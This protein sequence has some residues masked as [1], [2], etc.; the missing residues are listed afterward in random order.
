MGTGTVVFAPGKDGGRDGAFEGTANCFPSETAPATGKFVIQAK[1]TSAPYATTRDSDFTTLWKKELPKIATLVAEGDCDIYLLF[2][3]RR[4]PADHKK[5]LKA[6]LKAKGVKQCEV[7]CLQTIDL[8]LGLNATLVD[9]LGLNK[10]KPP[11]RIQPDDLSEVIR[12][13]NLIHSAPDAEDSLHDLKYIALDKKNLI[14]SLSK[15]YYEYIQTASMPFFSQIRDF[16][17]NPRNSGLRD[18]YHTTADEIRG[19]L[20]TFQSQFARFEEVFVLLYD[21]LI[22]QN[23][24]LKTKRR[25]VNVFLHYMYCDCDI[26]KKNA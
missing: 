5:Q 21:M 4:C 20:I 26:G 13:F 18:Q 12:D 17:E 11:F 16:L 25:L 3:N 14:N 24:T 9:S 19:K 6:D 2:T 10:Y 8:H 7:Y 23:A 22:A 1:H 15:D